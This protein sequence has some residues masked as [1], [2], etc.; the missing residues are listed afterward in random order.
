MATKIR[1][2]SEVA[3]WVHEMGEAVRFY[4]DVLGLTV[5]SPPN[6]Q[7]EVILEA[8]GPPTGVPQMVVLKQLPPE[9]RE[10]GSPRQIHHLTFEISPKDFDGEMERLKGL[11]LS[12]RPGKHSVIPSRT[13]SVDDPD[14]NEIELLAKRDW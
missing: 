6:V 9:S 7:D 13:I 3:L 2:I 4:R 11:G 5:I 10:F 12:V 14:G 1:G 8:G